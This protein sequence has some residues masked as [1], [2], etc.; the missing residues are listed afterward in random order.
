MTT[1]AT[2]PQLVLREVRSQ[3]PGIV[4]VLADPDRLFDAVEL[5]AVLAAT[6]VDLRDWDGTTAMLE[7]VALS[8]ATAEIVLRVAAS[9]SR[10]HL[11]D[12]HLPDHVH[13]EVTATRIASKLHRAVVAALPSADW[14]ACH[15]LDRRAAEQLGQH[16]TA[17]L[18]AR[19][20]YGVA[21]DHLALGGMWSTLLWL[22]A[23]SSKLPACLAAAVAREVAP[24]LGAG[25]PE[26][27]LAGWLQHPDERD[28]ELARRAADPAWLAALADS[29][30]EQAVALA[31]RLASTQTKRISALLW[32][33]PDASPQ[34]VLDFGL[35]ALGSNADAPT[36]PTS[37][38]GFEAEFALWIAQHYNTA[39][40]TPPEGVLCLHN[41][42]D[43]LCADGNGPRDRLLLVVLDA[44][45]LQ[46]WAAIAQV[47]QELG[48]FGAQHL[49][50]AFASLPTLTSVSRLA[51][52]DGRVQADPWRQTGGFGAER[53]A[54]K[55]HPRVTAKNDSRADIFRHNDNVSPSADLVAA[56]CRGVA[57]L[58][59]IDVG[60]DEAIHHLAVDD[61]PVAV[62][63][64]NWARL[65]AP[66]W[67]ATLAEAFGNGYRVVVTADHGHVTAT[68][69]GQPAGR[70]LAES[71]SRRA[72]LLETTGLRA[73][74]ANKGESFD[75][76]TAPTAVLPLFARPGEAFAHKGT[77]VVCHGGMSMQEV[78]VP[79]AE[80]RP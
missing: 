29:E 19:A 68:G 26:A 11:L 66:G 39:V 4:I 48:V 79:V 75:P 69:V 24:A 31:K 9:S 78:L 34:Q 60:W 49:R 44:V 71:W 17:V 57:R 65:R 30:R 58:A 62:A 76:V 5:R 20:I 61:Q 28:S 16:A 40:R 32:P 10:L 74:L 80:L 63:A 2:W 12:Q 37:V 38:A 51:I 8:A 42:V 22:R 50:A 73:A 6:N 3:I 13:V 70:E 77:R 53:A 35:A 21:A 36:P 67:R 52:F 1:T 47:W 14:Q 55:E 56:M 45:G 46:A 25:V 41:L 33:G 15:E 7:A 23:R 72:L 43:R 59:A 64:S 27:K 18:L 54:W